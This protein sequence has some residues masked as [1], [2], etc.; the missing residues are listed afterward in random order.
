MFACSSASASEA[1]LRSGVSILMEN[2]RLK[3]ADW[4][5]DMDSFPGGYCNLLL[6]KSAVSG[7]CLFCPSLLKGSIQICSQ[8]S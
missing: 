6:L 7:T 4:R 5:G 8:E 3:S 2:H 1:G